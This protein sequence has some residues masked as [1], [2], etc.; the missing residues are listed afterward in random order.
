MAGAFVRSQRLKARVSR[1]SL[2]FRIYWRQANIESGSRITIFV[3][4][5]R[6]GKSEH[7]RKIAQARK[8]PYTRFLLREPNQSYFANYLNGLVGHCP[9]PQ[10]DFVPWRI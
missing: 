3:L 10:F 6:A 9:R 1:P 4:S 7:A 8:V 2:H 5:K